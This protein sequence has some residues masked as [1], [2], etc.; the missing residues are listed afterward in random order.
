MAINISDKKSLLNLLIPEVEFNVTSAGITVLPCERLSMARSI[1]FDSPG[2]C[3]E[4][5][6]ADVELDFVVTKEGVYIN[7]SRV[8]GQ[9]FVPFDVVYELPGHCFF[10][11]RNKGRV[12]N[13]EH[14]QK[15]CQHN[16]TPQQF[17]PASTPI[18]TKAETQQKPAEAN[19]AKEF[20]DSLSAAVAPLE[21]A[22]NSGNKPQAQ[23]TQMPTE[24]NAAMEFIDKLSFA[25][26]PLEFAMNAG[27]NE[28]KPIE[29]PLPVTEPEPV[30][31]KKLI[32]PP[33]VETV[34]S[35]SLPSAEELQA[36]FQSLDAAT[37]GIPTQA[38][39]L[40]DLKRQSAQMEEEEKAAMELLAQRELENRAYEAKKMK[41][42]EDERAAMA[43]LAKKEA[44]EA[45]KM[46]MDVPTVPKY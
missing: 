1:P 5:K 28:L 17:I 15:E 10:K 37:T 22:M 11:L 9:R 3:R 26:A 21:F 33:K 12:F 45:N 38:E 2:R 30:P 20:I 29:K 24:N 36:F 40:R 43:G 8:K 34:E 16:T 25:V 13:I 41:M 7:C 39:T 35:D 14:G 27:Q 42:E 18:Q 23:P 6:S 4:C 46:E 19:V 31:E 44:F 32:E